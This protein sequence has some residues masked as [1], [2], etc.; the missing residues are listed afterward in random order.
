MGILIGERPDAAPE[1][2]APLDGLRREIERLI[3]ASDAELTD[4]TA[5]CEP[6][7]FPRLALLPAADTIY[8]VHRGLLRVGIADDRG[9]DHT[10]HFALEHQFIADYTSFILRTPPAYTLQALEATEV[11][12]I[13]RAAIEWGYRHLSEG[14]KLGRLVAENYFVYHDRRIQSGYLKTPKQRYD[15]ITEVFPDLHNRVPQQLIASY[16]GIT[17]VHLSRLKRA[18]LHS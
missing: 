12:A 17:P 8:F 4:F 15:A 5:R 7:L 11:V 2:P 3:A 14:Q 16:L 18:A 1:R 6:L 10:V 13:P 9:T